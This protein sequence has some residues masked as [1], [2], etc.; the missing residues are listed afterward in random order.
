MP[1][2]ALAHTR[3]FSAERVAVVLH[4]DGA[5]EAPVSVFRRL[6]DAGLTARAAHSAINDLAAEGRTTC[7]IPLDVDLADLARDLRRLNV[8]LLR[9]RAFA[10]PGAFIAEIRARHGLSQRAF[11]DALGLDVRTLQN[12]E[13]GRNRP[14]AAALSLVVLFDRDP[15]LVADAAYERVG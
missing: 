8:A 12:W 13:Q 4:R 11:A 3:T 7:E 14:D 15:A 2:Q 5:L 1:V 6:F 10:E 9:R